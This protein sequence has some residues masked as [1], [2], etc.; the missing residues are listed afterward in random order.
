MKGGDIVP[1]FYIGPFARWISYRY[2]GIARRALKHPLLGRL[3]LAIQHGL[4]R[5]AWMTVGKHRL[6]H[7]EGAVRASHDADYQQFEGCR[8]CSMRH[9][10]DGFHRDYADLFGSDEVRPIKDVPV[11]KDPLFYIRAQK[12]VVEPEDREWAL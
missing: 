6:Y 11:T 12:K 10:C 3:G 7:T 5:V 8:E 1:P 4:A 2:P 9:I